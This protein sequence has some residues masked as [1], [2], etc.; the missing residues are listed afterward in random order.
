[1]S[2]KITRM[3]KIK[4][5]MQ[6]NQSGASNREIARQLGL[7]AEIPP[8]V[9]VVA[10]PYFPVKVGNGAITAQMVDVNVV[11]A[12]GDH[13]ATITRNLPHLFFHLASICNS[14]VLVY[15]NLQRHHAVAILALGGRMVYC[16]KKP[17]S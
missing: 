6:L 4:Q 15:V 14:V 9:K 11:H 17:T 5:L 7:G 8:W 13:I 16:R 12:A 1:M 10:L 3:S 2:G